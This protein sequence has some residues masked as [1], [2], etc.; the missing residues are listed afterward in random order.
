M[1]AV[2]VL[3]FLVC[4]VLMSPHKPWSPY[5]ARKDQNNRHPSVT[6]RD[7]FPTWPQQ[8][9]QPWLSHFQGGIIMKLC[10]QLNLFSDFWLNYFRCVGLSLTLWDHPPPTRNGTDINL[11]LNSVTTIL[12]NLMPF[13]TSLPFL[14]AKSWENLSIFCWKSDVCSSWGPL[15]PL[16]HNHTANLCSF[17]FLFNFGSP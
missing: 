1:E 7:T 6:S 9:L 2:I 16:C 17:L 5:E 12:S 3:N 13:E 4:Q 11:I 15:L 14:L 8:L 10:E